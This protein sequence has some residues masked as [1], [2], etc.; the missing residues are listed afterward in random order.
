MEDVDD[1][2]PEWSRNETSH[3]GSS[4]A[5]AAEEE[6]YTML[7]RILHLPH[8]PPQSYV[9]LGRSQR[10]G[11]PILLSETDQEHGVLVA[12]PPGTGKTT[13]I[14][15]QGMYREEGH[16]SVFAIDPKQEIERDTAGWLA[17][18]H[19]ILSFAPLEPARSARYNPLAHIT[20]Y[21]DAKAFATSWIANTGRP[22]DSGSFWTNA[23]SILLTAAVLHLLAT[24][25][26]PPALAALARLLHQPFGQLAD[27]LTHSASA[28]A[29]ESAAQF[30]AYMRQAGETA[31]GV[32]LGLVPRFDLL[33]DPG[34]RAV[35]AANEVNFTAMTDPTAQPTALYLS[36]PDYAARD[37][38]PL[39]AQL[40]SQM[41]TAWIAA[42][43][44]SGGKLRRPIVA[45]LDEF[46]NAGYIPDFH[47]YISMCRARRIALIICVQSFAQLR[48]AYGPD[49]TQTILTSTATHVVFPRIG[50][51]E[52]R[53]YSDRIGQTT[54]QATSQSRRHRNTP[55]SLLDFDTD[56]SEAI[57]L[58]GVP[59]IRPEEL[60]YL[61]DGELVVLT[62]D[63][64]PLRLRRV[65]SFEDTKE[66]QERA[67]LTYTAP[68]R[69]GDSPA[70]EPDNPEPDN[71]A[72]AG[73][74]EPRPPTADSAPT[75]PERP[76]SRRPPGA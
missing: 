74:A 12:A 2:R 38:Q 11:K 61:P 17:Q 54:V 30:F 52:A 42:A 24:S 25:S 65:R 36:I 22:E 51:Q 59:L 41:F 33:T 57:H 62:K 16:R 69:P 60:V 15:Y 8:Q 37:L 26:E 47:R 14:I 43:N 71:A 63:T 20:S 35:T 6:R 55:G 29:H 56:E 7:A 40:I 49:H 76:R 75:T 34:I 19:R 32:M 21:L 13:G 70:P 50:Q 1:I 5:S 53:F 4:F 27:T 72:H 66:I 64:H 3:G 48:A 31:A 58:T 18:H 44:Q 67:R 39:S 10:T 46:T 73:R 28:D 23:E 9:Q 68:P 45:Y